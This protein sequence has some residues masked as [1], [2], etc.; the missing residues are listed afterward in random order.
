MNVSLFSP[1]HFTKYIW[2]TIKLLLATVFL[3]DL[4]LH[5]Q[6]YFLI[7]IDL[8]LNCKY[9]FVNEVYIYHQGQ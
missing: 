3:C 4:D 8:N 9:L 6:Y 7:F 2:Y 1:F 5:L